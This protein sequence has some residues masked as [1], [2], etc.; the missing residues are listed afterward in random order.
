MIEQTQKILGYELNNLLRSRWILLIGLFFLVA[1]EALFRFGSDPSKAVISLMNIVLIVLPL[2]SL[3]LGIIYF[4][5]SREFVELLLA[6]P[7]KRSSIFAGKFAGLAL[8][9]CLTFVLGVG[10]PFVLHA[11]RIGG[12]W[13][14]FS[15]LLLVG[16][17]FILVFVAVAFLIATRLEDRIK[18]FGAAILLWLYL[19]VVYDAMILLVIHAFR[20]YPFEQGMV[21]LAMMNPIDLGRIMIL[22]HLDIS[23]LMGYTGALFRQFYGPWGIL[24]AGGM[25]FAWICGPLWLGM[26]H[27]RR[28][29]F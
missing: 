1:T 21:T 28:R 10:A 20:E 24:L 6:Q 5:H 18:G 8:A 9:L 25:M 27:F 16:C 4:Y 7:I 15:V 26:H 19:S 22:L 12:Y 14:S 29:D 23:A 13:G 11:A 17:A 3:I 2:T